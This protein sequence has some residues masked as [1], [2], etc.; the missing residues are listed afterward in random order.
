MPICPL[1]PHRLPQRSQGNIGSVDIFRVAQLFTFC[2]RY[3]GTEIVENCLKDNTRPCWPTG[4]MQA[5]F[6]GSGDP[7]M[8]QNAQ[9]SPNVVSRPT[10]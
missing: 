7:G 1:G 8:T 10:V 3:K 6:V 2:L 9:H 4:P 5:T